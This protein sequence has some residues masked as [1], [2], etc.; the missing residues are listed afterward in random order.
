MKTSHILL[1]LV[2]A[3]LFM[4]AVIWMTLQGAQVHCTVCLEF[5]GEEVCRS[6]SGP[7]RERALQAA[8]ESACGGNVSG[9]AELIACRGAPPVSAQCSVD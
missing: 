1:I 7:D 4:G 9:M 2:V 3:G 5:A 6:G 8:Q